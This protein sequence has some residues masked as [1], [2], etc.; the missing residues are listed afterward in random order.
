VRQIVSFGDTNLFGSWFC[1]EVVILVGSQRGQRRRFVQKT[2]ADARRLGCRGITIVLD[3]LIDRLLYGHEQPGWFVERS[4]EAYAA[5]PTGSSASSTKLLDSVIASALCLT[6]AELGQYLD[7]LVEMLDLHDG[8]PDMEPEEDGC[9]S[10]D[11]SL[12]QRVGRKP[13]LRS[14]SLQMPIG[15]I[16]EQHRRSVATIHTDAS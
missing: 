9:E 6:R 16:G 14:S 3:I 13:R 5:V 4:R 8:D 11:N 1:L 15:K 12:L 2:A 7:T 10:E